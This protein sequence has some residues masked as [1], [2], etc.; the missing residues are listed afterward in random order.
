MTTPDDDVDNEERVIEH[1]VL[2]LNAVATGIGLGLLAGIGLLL[3]TLFLAVKGGP[4]TGQHLG[5]LGQY[6]PGYSVTVG[7][8][9]IGFVYAFIVGGAA[10]HLLAVIYNR[11][12]R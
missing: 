11:F 8:A 9:F 1:A 12:A 3:A 5:L 2:R 7:G 10:G 4:W 6:F